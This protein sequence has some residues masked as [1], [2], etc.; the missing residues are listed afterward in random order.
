MGILIY[1]NRKDALKERLYDDISHVTKSPPI[2]FHDHDSFT[3]AL[4]SS[5]SNRKVIV[6]LSFNRD[7]LQFILSRKKLLS[8]HRLIMILP[9]R[10]IECISMG[11]SLHPRFQTH[12]D[13]DFKEVAAVLEKMLESPDWQCDDWR[14]FSRTDFRGRKPGSLDHGSA[15][16]SPKPGSR[17]PDFDFRC[18]RFGS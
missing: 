9:D 1:A 14:R 3:R 17:I 2:C 7:D 5:M 15:V 6:F 10:S 13:G 16:R 8:F 18:S 12:R 4:R 11:H